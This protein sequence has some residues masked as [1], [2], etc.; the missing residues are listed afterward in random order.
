MGGQQDRGPQPP[1][2][3]ARA[4]HD[5]LLAG[6][7]HGAPSTSRDGHGGLPLRR[8]L[9]ALG[10]PEDHAAHRAVRGRAPRPVATL[11]SPAGPS[12]SLRR[13]MRKVALAILVVA[14]LAPASASARPLA[15]GFGDDA[16]TSGD[17]LARSVWL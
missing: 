4:R 14:L 12:P 10:R 11:R 2:A 9:V 16:F 6:I 17:P 13:C 5:R 15:L 1:A 8:Q 7:R 3:P